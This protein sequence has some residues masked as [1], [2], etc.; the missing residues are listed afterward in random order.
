MYTWASWMFSDVWGRNKSNGCQAPRW[1]VYEKLKYAISRRWRYISLSSNIMYE[2]SLNWCYDNKFICS[3]KR[4]SSYI[5]SCSPDETAALLWCFIYYTVFNYC[6]VLAQV[7]PYAVNVNYFVC[8]YKVPCHLRSLESELKNNTHPVFSLVW[9]FWKF[10]GNQLHTY[11]AVNE[12]LWESVTHIWSSKWNSVGISY[13][14][15]EQ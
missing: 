12:I 6:S 2:T 10:N 1:S 13:T 14:H 5:G 4:T 9:Y 15:M 7:N 3:Y 11:G 8:V